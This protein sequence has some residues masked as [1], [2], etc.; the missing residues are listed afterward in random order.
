[1]WRRWLCAVLTLVIGSTAK[2]DEVV[3]PDAVRA[4]LVVDDLDHPVQITSAPGEPERL[5]VVERGGE[6]RI[7]QNKKVLSEQLLD[8]SSVVRKNHPHGLLGIAFAPDF[9]TSG[10]FYAAYVD[11]QGDINVGRFFRNKESAPDEDSMTV[12]IKLA[13]AF[14]NTH[15]AAI[16]FGKD[17]YLYVTWG[18][19]GGPA[20]NLEAT[21]R[22]DSLFG[23]VLRLDVSK[24]GKYSVPFDN[25]FLNQTKALKEIWALGVRNPRHL[26]FDRKQGD[27][28]VVDEGERLTEVNIIERGKNYGWNVMEGSECASNPCPLTN[29][30]P[31]LFTTST[32]SSFVGGFIYRGSRFAELEGS[33]IF[34]DSASGAVFASIAGT[35]TRATRRVLQ[36][37]KNP[38]SAIGEDANGEIYIGT[39][40]G[41]LLTLVKPPTDSEHPLSR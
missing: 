28:L 26:S 2:A 8:I 12:V 27:L 29:G 17:G 4:E 24:A 36:L 10:Q 25:P 11:P 20:E 19:G 32:T 14:P 3:T 31:P 38:I 15:G 23:K 37:T 6:V 34:A 16:G 41:E 21:Q 22:L 7:V 1:M 5:Y 13:Q 33:Y 18:D 39:L 9:A 30:S 40:S 35:G